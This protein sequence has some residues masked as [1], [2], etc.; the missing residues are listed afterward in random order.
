MLEAQVHDRP[1]YKILKLVGELD[2]STVSICREWFAAVSCTQR[3]VIDLSRVP[4]I[5]SAGMGALIGGVRRLREQGG[6]V[7]V[8]CGRPSIARALH[9]I[10]LDH[11][12]PVADGIDDA[13][14]EL[15]SDQDQ[16]VTAISP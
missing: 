1:G 12:V 4:F 3:L 16:P 8:A 10:R 5:D 7:A 9:T 14:A 2:T 13:A 15:R 6:E 11:L